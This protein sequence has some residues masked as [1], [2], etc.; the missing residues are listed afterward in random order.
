VFY[1]EDL[2]HMVIEYYLALLK[3]GYS[4]D[5]IFRYNDDGC[6]LE[7][8]IINW[9]YSFVRNYALERPC[10]LDV[11][12]DSFV[13]EGGKDEKIMQELSSREED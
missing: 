12:L 2:F 7:A 11:I 13:L 8:R 9:F 5:E 10:G 4:K 3:E 6:L 1:F